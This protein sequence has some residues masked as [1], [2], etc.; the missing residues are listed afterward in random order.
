MLLLLF[1][2]IKAAAVHNFMEYF[3]VLI[4]VVYRVKGA[5]RDE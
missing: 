5:K 2:L 4:S 1:Y 3:V